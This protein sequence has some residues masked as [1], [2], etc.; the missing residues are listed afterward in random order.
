MTLNDM[1]NYG[2][3]FNCAEKISVPLQAE[4]SV[5][6]IRRS[7]MSSL[8]AHGKWQST[9]IDFLSEDLRDCLKCFFIETVLLFILFAIQAWDLLLSLKPL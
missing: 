9:Y 4:A 7:P 5:N 3:Y 8:V 2:C 6:L 1:G